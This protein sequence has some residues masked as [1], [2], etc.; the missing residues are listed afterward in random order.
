MCLCRILSAGLSSAGAKRVGQNGG[1]L[2]RHGMKLMEVWHWKSL[3]RHYEVTV[4]DLE[5]SRHCGLSWGLKRNLELPPSM[6][7]N[8]ISWTPGR[9]IVKL[10]NVA[11][12][13]GNTLKAAGPWLHRLSLTSQEHSLQMEFHPFSGLQE[14]KFMMFLHFHHS[15]NMLLDSFKFIHPSKNTIF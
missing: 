10:Q 9:N 8:A 4:I 6:I 12:W 15:V 13:E 14:F 11:P 1:H 5:H 3:W 2:W 7:S